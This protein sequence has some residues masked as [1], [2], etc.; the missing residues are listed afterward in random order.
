MSVFYG[1]ALTAGGGSDISVP[2]IGKHFNW[3]GGDGTYRVIDDG[4]KNWR[5]KFLSSGVFTTL[6]DMTIDVFLVGAGGG[7]SGRGSGDSDWPI[8]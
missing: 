4:D 5:I 3:T 1:R 8:L 6:K 2:I 7:G